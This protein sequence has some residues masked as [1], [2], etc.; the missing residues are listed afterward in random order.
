MGGLGTPFVLYSGQGSPV[1][2]VAYTCIILMGT[3]AIYLRQHW[4]SLLLTSYIGTNLT[5]GWAV[6]SFTS[7]Q[8]TRTNGE[9]TAVTYLDL[10][11]MQI[12]F[13]LGWIAFAVIPLVGALLQLKRWRQARTPM[14]LGIL[15]TPTLHVLAFLTPI[16]FILATGTIW[17]LKSRPFGWLIVVAALLYGIGGGVLRQRKRLKALGSTHWLAAAVLLSFALLALVSGYALLILL[18]LEAFCVH[19][20]A[21]RTTVA[22]RVM[23]HLLS[24]I[25]SFWSL[26]QFYD[27]VSKIA[28][29]NTQALTQ[30]G[31]MGLLL[32]A[33]FMIRARPVAR[34]YQFVLHFW[35]LAWLW[36]ELS[37]QG[38]GYVT[39]AW[40]LYAMVLLVIGLR[41]DWLSLRWAGMATLVLAVLKLLSYD[42]TNVNALW[43]IFLFLGFGAV[44]LGLSYALQ[45]LWR[46][47]SVPPTAPDRLEQDE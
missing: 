5:F 43:R 17:Q 24:G 45:D 12:G 25:V 39:V 40:G 15:K 1:S 37:L 8:L 7:M 26:V 9:L 11:G 32:G 38:V 35:L 22:M 33:S 44:F 2:L 6:L 28:V 42:L 3:S 36:R 30:L 27:S 14:K 20:V 4:P 19:F 10:V 18:A 21:R 29:L 13:G 41:Q 47:K 23:A 31:V 46:P 34:F 16:L